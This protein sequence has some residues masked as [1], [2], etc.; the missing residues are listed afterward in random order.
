MMATLFTPVATV[1]CSSPSALRLIARACRK[2]CFR[3]VQLPLVEQGGGE[4]A[5]VHRETPGGRAERAPVDR[6]RL[7]VELLRLVEPSLVGQDEGEAREVRRHVVVAAAQRLAVDGERLAQ[8][9]LRLVELALLFQDAG[10]V[11]EAPRDVRVPPPFSRLL[12]LESLAEQLL[13]LAVLPPAGE[14]P[15]DPLQALD[16]GRVVAAMQ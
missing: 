11:R 8:E 13:R 10:Q 16:D 14:H 5:Q 6:D 2:S 9:R 1:G 7:A 3:L 12:H 15:A 4:V